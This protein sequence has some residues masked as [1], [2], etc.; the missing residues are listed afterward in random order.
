MIS[1]MAL[2]DPVVG[3]RLM[4]FSNKVSGIGMTPRITEREARRE[5]HP[6]QGEWSAHAKTDTEPMYSSPPERV[7][8]A[9][10]KLYD[11]L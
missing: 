4:I 7:L 1:K 2:K 5:A 6:A 11:L 3:T 9:S 10:W 8:Y